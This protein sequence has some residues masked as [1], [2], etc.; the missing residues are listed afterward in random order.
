MGR[1][2]AAREDQVPPRPW[3]PIDAHGAANHLFAPPSEE[4]L[5]I[6]IKRSRDGFFLNFAFDAA[7]STSAG[8]RTDS[9]L[10]LGGAAR[11]TNRVSTSAV[12]MA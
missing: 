7:W 12:S 1:C 3:A 10:Y 9:G 6:E 5:G 11:V 2:Y 4:S 8:R